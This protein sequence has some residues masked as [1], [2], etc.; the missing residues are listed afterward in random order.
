M[1]FEEI[2]GIEVADQ[3]IKVFQG[4][5]KGDTFFVSKLDIKSS[6]SLSEALDQLPNLIKN[7]D[8]K[9]IVLFVPRNKFSV[10]YLGLPTKNII[11][12]RDMVKFKAKKQFVYAQKE[13]V[14][15][16]RIVGVDKR[17]HSK[18]MLAVSSKDAFQNYIT[19]F[20]TLKID[21]E[22][23]T[24]NSS[25]LANWYKLRFPEQKKTVCLVDL[26]WKETNICILSKGNFIYSREISIGVETIRGESQG[27][28]NLIMQVRRSVSAYNKENIGPKIES[29]VITGAV[30]EIEKLTA[31]LKQTS[32]L[33]I[34]SV[35][36]LENVNF[37]KSINDAM[38]QVSNR[39]SLAK[40][41]GALS[42]FKNFK[43]N[44]FAEEREEKEKRLSFYRQVAFY[45]IIS[46][47][48]FSSIV[49]II[50]WEFY[51]K[52]VY[53]EQAKE[54]T[55]T[56]NERVERLKAR[57]KVV[58]KVLSHLKRE[59]TVLNVLR[60]IAKS[61]PPGVSLRRFDYR[62]GRRKVN[63]DGIAKTSDQVTRF[64]R[65]LQSSY[66][67]SSVSQRYVRG[68]RKGEKTFALEIIFLK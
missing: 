60:E 66:F 12:I 47:L 38:V 63:I 41:L 53:L 51:R 36:P 31:K 34:N 20:K 29:I 58:E 52:I 61:A 13:V 8:T 24:M 16:F 42:D 44:F 15:S 25:G 22:I 49:A 43:I 11:E 3:M 57:K 17:G 5:V 68:T 65:N 10:R 46:V 14:H 67:F 50:G 4:K 33:E 7:L 35:S 19:P 40:V 32:E 56:I 62:Y 6:S 2:A 64:M 21:P 45:S 54:L 28:D 18:V 37:D 55:Q 9:R 27:L 1:A 39:T 48:L 26:D 30:E 23:A 59:G